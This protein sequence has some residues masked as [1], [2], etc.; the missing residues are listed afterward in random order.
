MKKLVILFVLLIVS[1]SLVGCQSD[2]P[3]TT[4]TPGTTTP[5]ATTPT[6]TAPATTTPGT[7]AP[8][9]TAPIT[10]TPAPNGN[11]EGSLEDIL[12][13]IYENAEVSESFREFIDTGLQ[14]TEITAENVVYFLGKD[15]IE[16]EAAIASEAIMSPSAYS[17][18][19]VRVAEDADIEQI[20]L[21][22]K[23]NVDPFKWVCVGVDPD[24][25]I[26]D[27][28]GNVIILIMSDY[29]G[30]ALHNSFQALAD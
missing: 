19:L 15:D 5:V 1:L 25:I 17:L 2:N 24:N 8:I 10:T 3:P 7:T 14:T 26:V 18:C 16:F 12:A 9:T 20:K 22:I 6:T 28:I 29:E 30:E 4:T 13:D 11:L 27:N 23:E 21:D